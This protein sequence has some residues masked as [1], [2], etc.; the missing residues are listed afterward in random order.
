MAGTCITSLAS[1]DAGRNPNAARFTLWLD[2]LAAICLALARLRFAAK[3]EWNRAN[4]QKQKEVKCASDK[5]RLDSRID[6]F[7]HLVLFF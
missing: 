4:S 7:F 1:C 6:L 5:M 2:D 3:R